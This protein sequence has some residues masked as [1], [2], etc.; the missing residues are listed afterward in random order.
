MQ[1]RESAHCV[2]SVF[3]FIKR[4][5]KYL[6]SYVA[7]LTMADPVRRIG[8]NFDES[9][10]RACFTTETILFLCRFLHGDLYFVD[11]DL[12]SF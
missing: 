5:K 12:N 6:F 3:P 2:R 7:L 10:Q 4:K 8:L 1:T 9:F 11:G